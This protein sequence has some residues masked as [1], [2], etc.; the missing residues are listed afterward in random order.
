MAELVGQKRSNP[1][2]AV[3]ADQRASASGP[4]AELLNRRTEARLAGPAQH[5]ARRSEAVAAAAP[6]PVQPLSRPNRTG[7]PDRLK[8][9]IEA[10]SGIAM[11]DVRVHRGSSEPAKLGALAYAHGRDIHL[12]PGHERHLP[13]EAWHVVQQKQGRVRPT[14][15]LKTFSVNDE[16]RLEKEADLMGAKALAGS[17]HALSAAVFEAAPTP[18]G[19]VQM[20]IA[21]REKMTG[22]GER[23]ANLRALTLQVV[24]KRLGKMNAAFGGTVSFGTPAVLEPL[25]RRGAAA[26]TYAAL[27][28]AMGHAEMVNV[29]NWAFGDLPFS[30]LAGDEQALMAITHWSEVGREYGSVLQEQL[31]AV[32]DARLGKPAASAEANEEMR[33]EILESTFAQPASKD[34]AYKPPK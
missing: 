24:N 22:E 20:T 5:L 30:G 21:E 25:V 8:A 26:P 31:W 17:H 14:F 28:G 19:A 9:G 29:S 6:R 3:G 15:Q 13:H 34:T 33:A 2:P 27:L 11:D 7:L 10:L 18:A 12:G 23:W 32:I 16:P 1:P 4:H